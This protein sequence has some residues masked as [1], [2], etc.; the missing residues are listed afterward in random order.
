MAE[1]VHA[2]IEELVA[3]EHRLWGLESAGRAG[4][5]D[6]AR[7]KQVEVELDRYRD[8]L[9]RRRGAANAGAD[10]DSVELVDEDTVEGYLQ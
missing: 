1:D 3:E 6:R 4:E 9:R 5:A 2:H 10:P 8:L 7:L